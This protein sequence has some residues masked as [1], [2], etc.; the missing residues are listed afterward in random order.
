VELTLEGYV[1][2][3]AVFETTVAY[4]NPEEP[5]QLVQA[6]EYALTNNHHNI[7]IKDRG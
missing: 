4:D 3:E 5:P 1:E 6:L 2:A 7:T